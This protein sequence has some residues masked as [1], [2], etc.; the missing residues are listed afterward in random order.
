MSIT[1]EKLIEN[2]KNYKILYDLSH[3]EYKNK[4]RKNKTWD[5]IG[6]LL[7]TDGDTLK[8]KWKNL[9]QTLTIRSCYSHWSRTKNPRSLQ[10]MAVGEANGNI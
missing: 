3:P 8:K 7:N 2:V 6:A 4:R 5:E 9:R 10:N 1:T